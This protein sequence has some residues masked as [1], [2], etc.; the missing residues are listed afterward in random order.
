MCWSVIKYPVRVIVLSASILSLAAMSGHASVMYD[1]RENTAQVALAKLVV[2]SPPAAA[3][4]PWSTT[5]VSD[6]LALYLN[7]G[8]GVGSG[9]LLADSLISGVSVN[10][11]SS[12]SELTGGTLSFQYGPVVPNDPSGPTVLTNV[13]MI[14]HPQSGLDEFTASTLY[15]F[16]GGIQLIADAWSVGD[17]LVAVPEPESKGIVLFGALLVGY[18]A[19][20]RRRSDRGT[21][22]KRKGCSEIEA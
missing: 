5:N 10:L 16:P 2:A 14:F 13:S 1:F 11:I 20:H 19:Q 21:K 12:G 8:Y 6:L 15:T 18:A 3:T 22:G 4:V 9:N 17:S 7:G